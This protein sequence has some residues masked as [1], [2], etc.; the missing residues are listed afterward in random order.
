MEYY[1]AYG[2]NLNVRQ[3]KARCPDGQP[4]KTMCLAN[5]RLLFKG[6]N[7]YAYLTIEKAIGFEVPIVIWQVSRQDI[8]KLD[9]Y[10]GYPK[11][12]HKENMKLEI[13]GEIKECF[14]YIMNDGYKS[15]KPSSLY[16][17]GCI[18][19]YDDFGFQ[20]KYLEEA[21]KESVND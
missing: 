13:S 18:E 8:K 20:H 6:H 19:G 16:Y 17:Q 7:N 14:I 2:S 11:L 3:M 5:Y 9:I 21:Y 12:Y 10:E 4:V 15:A 1:I